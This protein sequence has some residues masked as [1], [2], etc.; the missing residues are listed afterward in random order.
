MKDGTDEKFV[1]TLLESGKCKVEYLP[2]NCQATHIIRV[3]GDEL[4]MPI[5]YIYE[6]ESRMWNLLTSEYRGI[7]VLWLHSH[8]KVLVI[9]TDNLTTGRTRSSSIINQYSVDT[10]CTFVHTI[11]SYFDQYKSPYQDILSVTKCKIQT[12]EER[13]LRPSTNGLEA[14]AHDEIV[15]LIGTEHWKETPEKCRA[16]AIFYSNSL[17]SGIPI[18]TK[19]CTFKKDGK[20]LNLFHNTSG[21]DGM[22]LLCRPMTRVYI[23]TLVM[24]GSLAPDHVHLYLAKGSKYMSYLVPDPQLSTFLR[25]LSG[26]MRAGETTLMWPSGIHV[27]IM[28]L[29]MASY[30]SLCTPVWASDQVEQL[31]CKW[32][33]ETLPGIIYEI[34]RIQGTTVDI[35]MNGARVQD[36]SASIMRRQN[37]LQVSLMKNGGRR[38][39]KRCAKMVPYALGDFDAL[40]VFL[41]DRLRYFFLIP[42][43]ALMERGVLKSEHDKGKTAIICYFPSYRRGRGGRQSDN[44][45]QQYC[46]DV[47]DPEVT[48]KTFN[49]LQDCKLFAASSTYTQSLDH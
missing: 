40:F 37:G 6:L 1:T 5:K 48:T 42:A 2:N 12:R 17:D 30:V 24:P 31:N 9:H 33:Y 35:I 27:D 7:L 34:P 46:F 4:V 14:A 21:Y 8:S 16:D 43:Q 25:N 45:T 20:T 38:G 28:S 3:N 26:A 32:R 22:L 47:N 19:S 49:I 44:W 13:L 29:K 18:Q 23:G 15:S 10:V 41:P 11:L 39:S 36:K